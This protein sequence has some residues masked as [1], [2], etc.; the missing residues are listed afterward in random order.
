MVLVSRSHCDFLLGLSCLGL[1]F[2]LVLPWS[3]LVLSR[4][5]VW[6]GFALW[7][8]S[9]FVSDFVESWVGVWSCLVLGF[10]SFFPILIPR[11]G[12]LAGVVGG[13]FC[14][15]FLIFHSYPEG[16]RTRG[17]GGWAILSF[18]S[19]LSFLSRGSSCS[20]GWWV[21]QFVF[22]FSFCILIPRVF[23]AVE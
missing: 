22:P 13:P 19:H 4:V 14:L 9:V 17:G 12:V 20:R 21:G 3:C 16:R 23:L 11:V 1:E 5:G 10:F 6:S 15:F 7:F 18:L 8:G 2:G